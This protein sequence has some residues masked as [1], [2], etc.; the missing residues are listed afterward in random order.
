MLVDCSLAVGGDSIPQD[1]MEMRDINTTAMF[2]LVVEKD[3]VF[4][5]LQKQMVD[6]NNRQYVREDGKLCSELEI[7]WDMVMKA[8]TEIQQVIEVREEGFLAQEF[9]PVKIAE[10]SWV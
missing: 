1:V 2:V 5:R 9:L 4:Q 3:A 7:L 8:E 6:L 10:C